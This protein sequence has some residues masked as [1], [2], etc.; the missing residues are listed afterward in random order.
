MKDYEIRICNADGRAAIIAAEA[1]ISDHAAIRSARKLA[2][3]RRCE[4]W[5]GMDC[6]Y[7]DN[8]ALSSQSPPA[9]SPAAN[10]QVGW[11]IP[12]PAPGQDGTL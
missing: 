6:I 12:D 5:R 8:P 2:Q 4:V 11:I 9:N 3:G 1:Q 10:A 7:S